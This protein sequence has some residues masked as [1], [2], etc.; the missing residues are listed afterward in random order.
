MTAERRRSPEQYWDRV[1]ELF[2]AAL[3]LA[4][5]KRAAYLDAACAGDPE[6][7]AE[8]ASLLAA[9]RSAGEFLSEPVPDR[10]VRA[11]APPAANT[12]PTDARA[13]PPPSS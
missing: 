8:V 4:A 11:S 2:A 1:H 3:E 13:S 7:Y 6:V 12:P 9:H 10:R 5:A